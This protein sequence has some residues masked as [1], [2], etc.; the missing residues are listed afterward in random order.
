MKQD[1]LKNTNPSNEDGQAFLRTLGYLSGIFSKF[2]LESTGCVV[3]YKIN[4]ENINDIKKMNSIDIKER[5]KLA[6]S[7]ER[8]EDA[9]VLK[10]MLES[11]GNSNN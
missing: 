6:I 7:E 4:G 11:N 9:A 3:D 5:L 1:D 2:L 10:K 8:Y